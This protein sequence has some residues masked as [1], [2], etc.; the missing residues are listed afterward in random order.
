MYTMFI[1]V[2]NSQTITYAGQEFSD[3]GAK[4]IITKE[5]KFIFIRTNAGVKNLF[6]CHIAEVIEYI[7]FRMSFI[8]GSDP[9]SP[10]SDILNIHV[11]FTPFPGLIHQGNNHFVFCMGEQ[12]FIQRS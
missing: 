6:Q 7:Y 8:G 12:F 10:L 3:E 5:D 4:N 11:S 9:E 1:P 2:N